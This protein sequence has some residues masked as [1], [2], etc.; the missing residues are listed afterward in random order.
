[1][2][3]NLQRCI[4]TIEASTAGLAAETLRRR[5]DGRWSIAEIVEHL[6]LAYGGTAKG[7]DRCVESG[8]PAAKVFSLR[9]R[10]WTFVVVGLGYF[11]PG[12]PAPRHVMPTGNVDLQTAVAA[13]RRD[14]LWLDAA[15]TRAR[16]RFGSVK[17]LDHPRLGA[18]TVDQWLRFHWIHT[19][20]HDKQI[21]ERAAR[22]I[23]SVRPE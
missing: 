3:R 1:M 19:R 22:L 11:P 18:F 17:V 23:A 6:Q 7:L 8:Q 5:T 21:R 12:R 20:H 13:A 14:L 15:A 9:H 10:Y 16:E 2:N 4:D